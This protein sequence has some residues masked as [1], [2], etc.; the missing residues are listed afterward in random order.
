MSRCTSCLDVV[1]LSFS[2]SNFLNEVRQDVDAVIRVLVV[3]HLVRVVMTV[4]GLLCSSCVDYSDESRLRL[5]D[6]SNAVS[7][8]LSMMGLDVNVLV[9]RTGLWQCCGFG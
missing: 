9:R 2:F 4:L 8:L 7:L 6:L 5:R 1:W 3:K